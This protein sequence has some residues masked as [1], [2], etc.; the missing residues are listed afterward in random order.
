MVLVLKMNL[1]YFFI[2]LILV[3]GLTFGCSGPSEIEPVDSDIV[4]RPQE[5]VLEPID[6]N[7][8]PKPIDEELR[9]SMGAVECTI[10]ANNDFA[11]DIYDELKGEDENL[12]IS[13]WSITTALAMTYEGA[14]GNTQVEMAEVL[15]MVQPEERLSGFK[16][17][18]ESINAKQ[19]DYQLS[20]ANVLWAQKDFN[21]LEDYFNKVETYYSG[22]VTNLDF[23]D[24]TEK[25]RV[26]INNWVEEKT[27]DKIKNLIPKG[28]ITPL[29]RLILTNAVYFKGTWVLEFDKK[30]NLY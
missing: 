29:T 28:V 5:P 15:H 3:I 21:F 1:F 19:N 20:T 25:S 11:F 10:L 26:T 18:I 30:K 17:I 22:K 13:P 23:T 16:A 24:E 6:S 4:V 9:C 8:L 14:K 2:F 12:F 27:N 7:E